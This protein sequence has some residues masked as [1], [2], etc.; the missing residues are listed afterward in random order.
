MQQGKILLLGA[1]GH[2]RACIDVVEL[3]NN[4]EIAGIIG[5]PVEVGTT[6]LGY[7]VLGDDSDLPMLLAE[8]PRALI[9]VGQIKTPNNRIRLYKNLV[10]HGCELPRILSPL[11]YVSPHARVGAGTIVMHGAIINAGS[12]IGCNCIINSNAL[13]EHDVV[14]SDHCHVSTSAT[15]NGGTKIGVGTFIGSGAKIRQGI[16]IGEYCVIGMGQIVISDCENGSSLPKKEMAA[17]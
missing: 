4:F 8:Y 1:G 5:Q 17:S 3:E 11:A 2:A 14:I 7:T 15:I 16:V 6:I 12:D 13:V 10:A 9:T